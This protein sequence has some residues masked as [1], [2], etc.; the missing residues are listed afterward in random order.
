MLL[1][2]TRGSG[3]PPA[4]VVGGVQVFLRRRRRR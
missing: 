4:P 2:L 3:T 1:L